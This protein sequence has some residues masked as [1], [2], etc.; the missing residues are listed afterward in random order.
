MRR[1]ITEFGE[2]LAVGVIVK[3]SLDF[4]EAAIALIFNSLR[5]AARP[6]QA[7]TRQVYWILP[8]LLTKNTR[9]A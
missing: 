3:E 4:D 7:R 1:R 5:A 6:I 9:R 8:K 2:R